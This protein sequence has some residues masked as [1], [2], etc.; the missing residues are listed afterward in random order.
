MGGFFATALNKIVGKQPIRI[1]LL[2]L[3][4]AG[5]TTLLYKLHI[6]K[7]KEFVGPWPHHPYRYYNIDTAE[8][9]NF[10][11][12]SWDL[13]GQD[14][15][16]PLWRHFYA[17]TNGIVYIVDS[18][19]RDRLS[20]TFS[21]NDKINLLTFGFIKKSLSQFDH[22]ENNDND[23]YG[24]FEMKWPVDISS[25]IFNYAKCCNDDILYSAKGELDLLLAE[26]DLQG[27]PLLVFANKQ[28]LPNVASVNEVTNTLGLNRILQKD[29]K[30]HIEPLI[31]TKGDGINEGLDWLS[32]AIMNNDQSKQKKK[33][34][35]L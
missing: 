10:S 28:D 8:F 2:G 16:R 19:D 1:L 12:D 18:N 7:N 4:A 13:G 3:D 25:I 35:F 9:D 30:W 14:K 26:E 34:R 17:N 24:N 29:R 23:R 6:M 20:D 5:K 33:I 11:I 27:V 22:H 31:A 15:M 32:D 21:N